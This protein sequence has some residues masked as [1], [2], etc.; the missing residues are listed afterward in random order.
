MT[1]PPD[2]ITPEG[3]IAWQEYSLWAELNL[4]SWKYAKELSQKHGFDQLQ[5]AR[6]VAMFAMADAYLG[7]AALINIEKA[8][9]LNREIADKVL[10]EVI[11]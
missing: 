11:L 1:K 5:D 3:D 9:G 10:G 7:H 8:G 4:P 2:L 6:I